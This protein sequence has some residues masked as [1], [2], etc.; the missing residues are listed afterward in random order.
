MKKETPK[1]KVTLE[2]IADSIG[3]LDVGLKRLDRKIDDKI[4]ELAISTANGFRD[5]EIRLT[6]KID[7]VDIRVNAV[8]V[9]VENLG[10]KLDHTRK[11]LGTRID[12]LDAKIGDLNFHKVRDEVFLLTKRVGKI[13]NKVGMKA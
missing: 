10:A 11:D 7:T 3:K 5:L 13:E 9:K 1:K 8:E 12:G 4:D 2:T 6:K